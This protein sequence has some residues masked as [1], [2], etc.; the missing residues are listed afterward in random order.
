M[1]L[2]SWAKR[3]ARKAKKKAEEAKRKAE[4]KARE[5]AE[6]A[7]REARKAAETAERKAREARELADRKAREAK[8]VFEDTLS[9]TTDPVERL[10]LKAEEAIRE[11]A[12]EMDVRKMI[13]EEL[14]KLKGTIKREVIDEVKS[15]VIEPAQSA[16]TKQFPDLL[17]DFAQSVAKGV[18]KEGLKKT[19]AIVK[20]SHRELEKLEKSKPALVNAINN[21]G[22]K[23]EIGPMTL[24]YSGFYTRMEEVIGVLDHYINSPPSIRRR[25]IIAMIKA[26]GPD[27]VDLGISIQ[28]VALVVGS[29]ELGVG[30]GL[31]DISIEL[32]AEIADAILEAAGLPE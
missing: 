26:L 27:S 16:L 32:F 7:A 9:K 24:A 29:K 15:E 1:G 21:L 5:A 22:G 10:A 18:T 20:V 25:D 4:R 3:Q 31:N 30:G 11:G 28:V 12:S 23:V 19:Q 13:Q 2:R 17:E 14:G 8:R 6:K